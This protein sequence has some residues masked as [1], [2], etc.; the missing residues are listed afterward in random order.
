MELGFFTSDV[1]PKKGHQGNNSVSMERAMNLKIMPALNLLGG[2][3]HRINGNY[4]K[5][6]DS[7]YFRWQR[8]LREISYYI[9]NT[10][11][12][13]S[14]F[15]FDI[16]EQCNLRCRTCAKWKIRPTGEELDTEQWKQLILQ[17]KD[18]VGTYGFSFSG[19]EPLLR[20]DIYEL[21]SFAIENGISPHVVSNGWALN[22]R[23]ADQ[24]AQSGI[25]RICLSLNGITSQVHN[26]TRGIEGSYAKVLKAI[27]LLSMKGVEVSIATVL[28]GF[29]L[30][31]ILKLTE[32]VSKHDGICSIGFQ[33]LFFDTGNTHYEKGWHHDNELWI[34]AKETLE[35]TIDSLIELKKSGYPISNAVEQL[36]LM[37]RYFA[38]PD[39][40]LPVKCKVGVHNFS[41]DPY[42]DVRL[43]FMMDPIGNIQNEHPQIIWNS[44]EAQKR[45]KQIKQCS[46]TCRLQNCNFKK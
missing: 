14:S 21:I 16:T 2:D 46:L 41:V 31:E 45:R 18:W 10:L 5:V 15:V 29:N 19:G 27:D 23:A 40:T 7:I 22:Q 42:G 3:D 34:H 9:N 25:K 32:W 26:Y 6:I 4:K 13:P 17:I 44:K 37:K 12:Q 11:C 1:A 35:V 20:R 28:M 30:K 36:T 38:D 39:V 8:M 43:C 33:P 24:L